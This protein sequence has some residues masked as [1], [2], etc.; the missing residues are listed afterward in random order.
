MSWSALVHLWTHRRLPL[1]AFLLAVLATGFFAVRLAVATIYWSDPAHLQQQP[2][3]WMT[4]GY[5]ARS[6]EIDPKDVATAL[7]LDA[8]VQLHGQTLNDIAAAQGVPVETL[9]T[10]LRLFLDA[11]LP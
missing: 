1:I 9:I 7:G 11:T 5:I 8:K 2:D 4:P 3:R 10:D 6:W